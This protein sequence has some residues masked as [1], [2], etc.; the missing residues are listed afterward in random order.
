MATFHVSFSAHDFR[1]RNMIV[2]LMLPAAEQAEYDELE[3]E[4]SGQ[5]EELPEEESLLAKPTQLVGQVTKL[6]LCCGKTE[7][8]ALCWLGYLYVVPFPVAMHV[9]RP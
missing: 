8:A 9:A 5:Q 2:L 7:L 1:L 6:G 4:A 3:Y